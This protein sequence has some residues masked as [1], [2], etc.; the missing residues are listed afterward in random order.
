MERGGKVER[1]PSHNKIGGAVIDQLCVGGGQPGTGGRIGVHQINADVTG[2]GLD[3]VDI[4]SNGGEA[5]GTIHLAGE[6][7][8]LRVAVVV[9]AVGGEV[10]SGAG[11]VANLQVAAHQ[12]GAGLER[13]HDGVRT[14]DSADRSHIHHIFRVDCEA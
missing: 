14:A 10:G 11:A 4:E 5:G 2:A 9:A 13:N 6:E 7:N 8:L 12:A 3:G 1:V